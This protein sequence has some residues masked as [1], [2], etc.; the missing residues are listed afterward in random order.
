M[1]AS[2]KARYAGLPDKLWQMLDLALHD[3]EL[4]ER[5]SKKYHVCMHSWHDN[6]TIGGTN[7]CSVCL[8]GSIMA[9]TLKVPVEMDCGPGNF[10]PII[11]DKL[12]AVDCCRAG[13]NSI[14]TA[15]A[16]FYGYKDYDLPEEVVAKLESIPAMYIP[17]YSHPYEYSGPKEFK[18]GMRR[19]IKEL[20]KVDL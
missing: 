9:C 4:V 17:S 20:K 16:F 19:L 14:N 15:V 3:L 6:R 2:L 8:A 1:V 13:T 11:A 18:K 10:P 5:Q 12:E 7:K